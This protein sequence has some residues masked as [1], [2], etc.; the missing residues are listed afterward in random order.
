MSVAIR[1]KGFLTAPRYHIGMHQPYRHRRRRVPSNEWVWSRPID[2]FVGLVA[3][4]LTIAGGGSL[5]AALVTMVLACALS[6]AMRTLFKS[7]S[8]LWAGKRLATSLMAFGAL[9]L[10]LWICYRAGR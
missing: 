5:I 7:G 4:G 8:L 1:R 2:P 6:D 3:F 9:G 10:C